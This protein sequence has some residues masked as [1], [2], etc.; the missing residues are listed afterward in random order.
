MDDTTHLNFAEKAQWNFLWILTWAL[1]W[2]QL[3]SV[4]WYWP[5][6]RHLNESI[7]SSDH[8]SNYY[9]IPV[10]IL[11]GVPAVVSRAHESWMIFSKINDIILRYRTGNY[12]SYS[13]W[14]CLEF[15]LSWALKH[16]NSGMRKTT[17]EKTQSRISSSA[18]FVS[19]LLVIILTNK[20]SGPFLRYKW[21]WKCSQGCDQVV[22]IS[23]NLH[24]HLMQIHYCFSFSSW[25]AF[26]EGAWVL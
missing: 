7:N 18:H 10:Y 14:T 26:K 13:N 19:I 17:P 9:L 25:G 1:E 23:T 5:T 2:Y 16:Q 24:L 15:E 20:P 21:G 4:I 22:L 12:I 6:L 11:K 8:M 3:E